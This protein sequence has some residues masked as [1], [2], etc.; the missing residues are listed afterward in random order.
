MNFGWVGVDLFFVLSGYLIGGILI[1]NRASPRY[2]RAF[3]ARRVCRIFPLYYAW[4]ALTA[5]LLAVPVQW[6]FRDLLQPQIPFW[7]Y[8]SY[9]QNMFLPAL[10]DFG[11]LWFSVTWSLA[12]EEQFYLLFPLL[13]RYCSPARLPDWLVLIALTALFCRILAWAFLPGQGLAGYVLLPC[14]WDSLALGALAAW[15]VRQPGWPGWIHKHEPALWTGAGF[16]I[17]TLA[18]LHFIHQGDLRSLGM[19]LAGFSL[20]AVL[21]GAVLLLA[22]HSRFKPIRSLL[23]VAPLRMLGRISYGVYLIHYP[24]L[25]V[26]DRLIDLPR[27]VAIP[28]AFT[29]TVGIAQLSW[30][31]FESRIIAFGR[32]IPY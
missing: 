14:R 6:A 30:T 29:L 32:K 15:S 2:F 1:D 21:F 12:I 28:L 18:G 24:V 22:T 7:S 20:L 27:I 10:N 17:A 16:I 13:V 31:L 25:G 26:L 3:Y 11:T 8:P 19:H 4:I 23:Q 5:V 9:T